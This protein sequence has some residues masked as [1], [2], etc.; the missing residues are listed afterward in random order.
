MGAVL[1]GL[2]LGAA[3]VVYAS[4]P[5]VISGKM[6]VGSAMVYKVQDPSNTGVNCYVVENLTSDSIAISCVK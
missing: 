3:G 1:G 6:V 2:V 5:L 4:T